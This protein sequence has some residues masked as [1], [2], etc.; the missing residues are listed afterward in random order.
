MKHYLVTGV[1]GGEA[2]EICM[3]RR[4]NTNTNATLKLTDNT[5][6][7]NAAGGILGNITPIPF[8]GAALQ[9]VIIQRQLGSLKRK[10]IFLLV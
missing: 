6:Y 8:I 3:F 7:N 10:L 9:Y 5:L 2:F 4:N 1:T